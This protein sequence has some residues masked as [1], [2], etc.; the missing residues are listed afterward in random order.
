MSP[1]EG[2]T[3]EVWSDCIAYWSTDKQKARAAK[4][5]ESRGKMKFLGGWGSKPIVSH[6]VEGANPDTGELPTAVETFRKFHHKGNDWRNEFAQQAY[7]SLRFNSI[8]IY[9]FQFILC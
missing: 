7:V 8:F 2:V 6:V 1:P 5:K 3:Q 4:N 9:F